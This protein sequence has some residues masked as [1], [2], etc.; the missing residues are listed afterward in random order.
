MFLTEYTYDGFIPPKPIYPY[1]YIY[2]EVDNK[3][4]LRFLNLF[5]FK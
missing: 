5:L 1:G 2:L 3:I 4:I